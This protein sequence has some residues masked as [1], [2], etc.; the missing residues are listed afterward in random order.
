M[1]EILQINPKFEQIIPPLSVDEFAQLEEN[2]LKLGRITEPIHVWNGVIIDGHHRYKIALKYPEITYDIYNHNFGSEHEAISWMCNSQLGRRNLTEPHK[3]YLIGT[4]YNTE[5]I[6]GYYIGNQYTL[7]QK[8]GVGRSDP[9]QNSHGKRSEIAL[10]NGVSESYVKRAACFAEGVDAAEEVCAGIK[11]R[12]LS[13]E[14]EVSIPELTEIAKLPPDERKVAVELLFVPKAKRSA[15]A[16][17]KRIE[18]EFENGVVDDEE[19]YSPIETP[20]EIVDDIPELDEP[21]EPIQLR[22]EKRTREIEE[23]IIHSMYGTLNMFI[24]SINDYLTRFPKLITE[25]K[26]RNQT[27]ELMVAARNYINNVEGELK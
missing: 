13:E 4:R 26:Y 7:P 19:V 16:I 21:T 15:H 17:A 24:E 5:K 12:I 14:I 23:S 2:I 9:P 1:N 18:D 3:R 10:V 11:Q 27:R 8:S 22:K 25:P 6:V 20:K